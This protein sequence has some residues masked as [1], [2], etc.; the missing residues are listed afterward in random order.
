MQV[1]D[2]DAVGGDLGTDFVGFAVGHAALDAATSHPATE[3]LAVVISPG[4][5]IDAASGGRGA[6]EFSAPDDESLVEE[7]AL[8]Q[9]GDE[10][11]GRAVDFAGLAGD[12]R[13][14]VGVVIPATCVDLDE[15]DATLDETTGAEEL[16]TEVGLAVHLAN[17]LRLLGDVKGVGRRGLHAEREFKGL[18]AGLELLV[19]LDGLHVALIQLA[20]EVELLALRVLRGEFA[21]QI[22]DNLV[23]RS[24]G[25][26]R[27]VGTLVE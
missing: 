8:L 24:A 11:G 5:R 13:V 15:A 22:R 21:L 1:M 18:D 20:H 12:G 4:G 2:V 17:L 23:R 27:G 26:E 19:L 16:G 7:T 10:S 25:T 14:E 9:I 3:S 6:A